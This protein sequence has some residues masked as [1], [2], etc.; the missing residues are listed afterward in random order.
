MLLIWKKQDFFFFKVKKINMFQLCP[1]K[2]MNIVLSIQLK[3]R[4][5]VVYCFHERLKMKQTIPNDSMHILF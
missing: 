1:H 4:H 3:S 5:L 2:L